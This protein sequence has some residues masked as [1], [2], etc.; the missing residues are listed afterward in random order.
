[1]SNVAL[2]TIYSVLAAVSL[3]LF[4]LNLNKK[5]KSGLDGRFNFVVLM[6]FAWQIL[7]V[8][9]YAATD[10]FAS[11]YL[12]DLCLPFVAFAALAWF[13]YIVRFYGLDSYFP[14][15]VVA[16]FFVIPL[17]TLGL[18]L[19]VP[20]HNFIR[21]ELMVVSTTPVHIIYSV[22]G[23]WFWYHAAYCYILLIVAFAIAV[24]QHAKI[25]RG[26]RRPSAMLL[27]GLGVSMCGNVLVLAASTPLD[28]S[29]VMAGIS[30]VLLY[31]ATKNN[32]SF[33]F[34]LQA[35][36]KVYHRIDKAMLILDK[37]SGI[38]NINGT[39]KQWLKNLGVVAKGRSYA[40]M[41]EAIKKLTI[42]IET[43]GEDE[44]GGEDY[45]FISGEVLNVRKKP[46][47]DNQQNQIGT[48]LI[49][50]DVKEN[51]KALDYLDNVAGMDIL[52]GL[53]NRR[54]LQKELELL[55]REENLPLTIIM[56]DL[57]HLKY[58]NDRFG[59][60]QG[61]AYIRVAAETLKVVCPPNAR[62]ARM[63]GDEFI[64][65]IPNHDEM[66]TKELMEEIKNAFSHIKGYLFELSIALGFAVKEDGEGNVEEIVKIADRNMYEDKR[67]SKAAKEGVAGWEKNAADN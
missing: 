65:V 55:D 6:L 10:R 66:R 12:F 23:P 43:R 20:F 11:E 18:C 58:T 61:D 31:F 7:L 8:L 2:I 38:V 28:L 36:E 48:F 13:L 30:S 44:D 27:A 37:D 53:M 59:H 64:M 50:S 39:A 14:K 52:T 5:R 42:R 35:R 24:Y 49:V 1:M 9:Y 33:D 60:A 15:V 3:V 56:G 54:K 25:N 41:E 57:N 34:F 63:G 40:A 21:Q 62:I 22:R 47:M 51:R 26:Y 32:Q 67:N 46:I 4:G 45:Y 19:T 17:F 29:L 16:A